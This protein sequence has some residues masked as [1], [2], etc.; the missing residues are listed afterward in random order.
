ME[1]STISIGSKINYNESQSFNLKMNDNNNIKL[2]I[3]YNENIISFEAVEENDFPK[4]EYGPA[5]NGQGLKPYKTVKDA[6]G[7]LPPAT[8]PCAPDT[9]LKGGGSVARL[10]KSSFL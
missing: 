6:I 5:D 8:P 2:N 1:A 3:S 10:Q 4:K 7:G 9:L